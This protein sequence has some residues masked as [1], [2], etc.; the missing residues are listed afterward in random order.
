MSLEQ[1]PKDV[2]I[3]LAMELPLKDVTKLCQSSARFNESICNSNI[4]WQKK[5]LRDF[6]VLVDVNQ[7]KRIYKEIVENRKRCLE[8]Q[9]KYRQDRVLTS[10][11]NMYNIY[12]SSKEFEPYYLEPKKLARNYLGDKFSYNDGKHYN[13]NA[14]II[15][16]NSEYQNILSKELVPTEEEIEL[17]KSFLLEIIQDPLYT[18]KFYKSISS[19]FYHNKIPFNV[20]WKDLCK[21]NLF[22]Y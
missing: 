2:L 17:L 11:F 19:Q 16:K 10:L 6:N 13:T 12:L 20:K 22:V 18:N 15:L 5:V 21:Y 14:M 8:L 7:A 3:E 9:N 1:L 4:F